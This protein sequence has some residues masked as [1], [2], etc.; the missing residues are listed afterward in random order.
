LSA[1][2]DRDR[3]SQVL[4]NLLGNAIKFTPSGGTVTLAAAPSPE[5]G[6]TVSVSD[7][8]PGVPDA[9]RERIFER[10]WQIGKPDR[11]GLGLG[12]YISKMIVESHGGR[13]FVDSAAGK[14]STFRFT[15]P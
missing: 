10:F 13:I 11:Q 3:V 14:G 1:R 5:G 6:V 9:L 8:G 15:L 4:S 12:L 7:T 2:C